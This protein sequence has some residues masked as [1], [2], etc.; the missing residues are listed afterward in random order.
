ME[1]QSKEKKNKFQKIV[2]S[3]AGDCFKLNGA[4]LWSETNGKCIKFVVKPLK[5]YYDGTSCIPSGWGASEEDQKEFRKKF[6]AFTT[7]VANYIEKKIKELTVHVE[8][9]SADRQE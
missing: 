2:R 4:V 6:H 7:D 8:A 5:V 9:V 3:K 1:N